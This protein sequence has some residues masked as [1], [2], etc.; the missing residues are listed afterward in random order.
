MAEG[1][2]EFLTT[3]LKECELT[4]RELIE[5]IAVGAYE[6]TEDRTRDD[7]ILMLQTVDQLKEG[8]PVMPSFLAALT[9][10]SSR[11]KE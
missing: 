10:A 8:Q 4:G 3:L 7:G 5:A 6:M 9:S 11:R 2:L 1:A